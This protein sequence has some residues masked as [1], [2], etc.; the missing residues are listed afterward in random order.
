MPVWLISFSVILRLIGFFL[1][2]VTVSAILVASSMVEDNTLQRAIIYYAAI[3]GACGMALYMI[4]IFV[5][6]KSTQ[7]RGP[8]SE[9]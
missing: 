9:T 4:G 3:A 7:I 2:V 1:F 5:K 6:K 8:K